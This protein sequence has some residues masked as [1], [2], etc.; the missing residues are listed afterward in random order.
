MTAEEKLLARLARLEADRDELHRMIRN[1][2]PVSALQVLIDPNT[3]TPPPTEG[4]PTLHCKGG[5]GL[6]PGHLPGCPVKAELEDLPSP[7]EEE[8][9]EWEGKRLD[10]TPYTVDRLPVEPPPAEEKN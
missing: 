1:G 8:L 9:F 5:E 6:V 7:A 2:F 3:P 10:G 4:C